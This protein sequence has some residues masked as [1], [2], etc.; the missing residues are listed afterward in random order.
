MKFLTIISIV[1]I[2]S[3]IFMIKISILNQD[4]EELEDIYKIMKTNILDEFF[5]VILFL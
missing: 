5:Q 2:S 1:V 4:D 3:V